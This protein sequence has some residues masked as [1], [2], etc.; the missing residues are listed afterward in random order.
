MPEREVPL[1]YIRC[2]ECGDT[3]YRKNQ[4]E[5]QGSDADRIAALE[6]RFEEL[7]ER[8]AALEPDDK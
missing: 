1:N 6:Q 2:S 5:C 8:V 3:Y 7:E 4:H